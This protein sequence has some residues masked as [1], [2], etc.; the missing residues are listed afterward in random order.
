MDRAKSLKTDLMKIEAVVFDFD[1]IFTDN[2]VFV[3]E[4]G[5]EAVVC[6]RSDGLGISRLRCLGIE[7]LIL[8]TETNPV[9]TKRAQKLNLPVIQSVEDKLPVLSAWAKEKKILME[10]IAYLGN[11]IND[12][13]CLKKV[14]MPVVVA[15]AM[16]EVKL[17]ARVIL[18][19]AGG[20][21][22]VREFCDALWQAKQK[23]K[24]S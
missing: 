14:G 15:D 5:S 21:G 8:S 22:A 13:D 16:P 23:G 20:K 19:K 3:F 12:R 1:G 18:E 9:V 7:M 10:R 4:D 2:R 17:L 11:D 6:S 24:K